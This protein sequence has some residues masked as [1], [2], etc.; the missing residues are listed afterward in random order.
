MVHC[1]QDWGVKGI[2]RLIGRIVLVV[3]GWVRRILMELCLL[4][5]VVAEARFEMNEPFGKLPPLV[6][7]QLYGLQ[8]HVV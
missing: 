6:T 8:G 3:Q 4:V 7:H 2:A 1:G 5:M